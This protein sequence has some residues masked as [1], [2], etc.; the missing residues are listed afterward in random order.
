MPY[1]DKTK[2]VLAARCLKTRSR[3]AGACVRC[4]K[5]VPA[6]KSRF[7]LNLGEPH[8]IC[9]KCSK[10]ESAKSAKR[11]AA[12]LAAGKCGACGKNPLETKTLCHECR[13]VAKERA[14]EVRLYLIS[15]GRCTSCRKINDSHT[16]RCQECNEK[17]NRS[18]HG[19]GSNA[20]LSDASDAFAP[21][22]G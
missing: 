2:A 14:K 12:N 4:G 21:A 19:H 13:E 3:A 6:K 17:H 10:Q 7:Q 22:S 11:Y 9:A 8:W 15:I 18:N 16:T 20:K 5:S 1:L